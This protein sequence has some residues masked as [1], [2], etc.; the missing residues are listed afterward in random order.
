MLEDLRYEPIWARDSASAGEAS[1][2]GEAAPDRA[3]AYSA[4]AQLRKRDFGLL[5]DEESAAIQAAMFAIAARLPIRRS[6]RLQPDRR[7]R[8]LDLRFSDALAQV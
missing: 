5:T 3:L 8:Q 7:G 6:R 1:E 2:R 4:A